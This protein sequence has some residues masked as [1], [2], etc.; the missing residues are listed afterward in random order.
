MDARMISTH[1]FPIAPLNWMRTSVF[2]LSRAFPAWKAYQCG[3]TTQTHAMI[4]DS[5]HF[6][7]I[8]KFFINSLTFM[9]K[10]TPSHWGLSMKNL[11]QAYLSICEANAFK[12]PLLFKTHRVFNGCKLTWEWQIREERSCRRGRRAVSRR[13]IC[14]TWIIEWKGMMN[15]SHHE[16]DSEK[17]VCMR[18]KWTWCELTG[19]EHNPAD[20]S[21][22]CYEQLWPASWFKHCVCANK[23]IIIGHQRLR[24]PL[25]LAWLPSHREYHP[26]TAKQE[27]RLQPANNIKKEPYIVDSVGWYQSEDLEQM[28]LAH[29]TH[30]TKAVKIS[31][32]TQSYISKTK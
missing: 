3:D 31:T 28:V 19:Q 30:N 32:K 4:A 16:C 5:F 23:Q 7:H 20:W 9:M 26:T 17:F 15:N 13:L 24:S 21:A 14:R 29:V 2:L 8:S 22:W 11:I 12:K 10:G 18:H 6:K 27:N 1:K 25:C